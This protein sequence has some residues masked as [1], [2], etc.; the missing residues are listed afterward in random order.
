MKQ[1]RFLLSFMLI[2]ACTTMYG[3]TEITGTVVDETGE[4]VI[5]ATVME[6]GTTKGTVTD[7]DGNFKLKVEAGKIL[8]ISYIGY[9]SQELP[10]QDGMFVQL[11]DN[12]KELAEVVGKAKAKSIQEALSPTP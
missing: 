2:L 7:F 12:A 5:G 10:A 11:K 9:D 4:G 3:Q 8:V 1:I 6:K